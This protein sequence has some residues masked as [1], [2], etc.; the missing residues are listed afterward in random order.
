VDAQ[1]GDALATIRLA[2]AARDTDATGEIGDDVNLLADR[3]GASRTSVRHFAGQ[4]VPD[5]PRIFEE[6]MRTSKNMKIGPADAGAADPNYDLALSGHGSRPFLDSE[7]ARPSADQRSHFT[8]P[9][10]AR[11]WLGRGRLSIPTN[12]VG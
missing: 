3:D 12:E 10:A 11:F 4:F 6:R 8:S 7:G 1:D 2:A 9:I 5:D